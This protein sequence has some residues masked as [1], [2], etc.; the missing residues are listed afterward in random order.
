LDK[1]SFTNKNNVQCYNVINIKQNDITILAF[2]IMKQLFES[3]N[4]IN[5]RIPIKGMTSFELR[6]VYGETRRHQDGLFD[7]TIETDYGKVKS[8]RSLT[9]IITLNDNFNGGIYTFHNQNFTIKPKKGTAILFPPYYT[10]P[11]S[12]SHVDNFRYICSAW[13][14]DDFLIKEN[15]CY[16]CDDPD[17]EDPV[18]KEDNCQTDNIW[19]Y[20]NYYF[21]KNDDK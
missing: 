5:N 2:S 4:Q 16:F 9:M 1:L 8:T 13:A 21:S 3:I 10:H 14:L 19:C 15:T 17:S 12:V 11:H 18:I 20:K 6:K 7:S